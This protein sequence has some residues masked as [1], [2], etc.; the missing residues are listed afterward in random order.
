MVRSALPILESLEI[1]GDQAS[2]PAVKRM[3]WDVGRCV[4]EGMPLSRAFARHPHIFDTTYVSLVAAGEASGNLDLMLERLTNH[5]DFSVKLNAKIQSALVYP[6]IVIMTAL[7]IV[8][9]LAAFVL[10]T[11][12]DIFV[13]LDIA[14]PLAT[15]IL[16]YGG[17][18]L[19]R[20]WHLFAL[21]GAAGL[22]AFRLWF[23]S[24]RHAETVDRLLLGLPLVGGL[25]R[26]IVLTRVLR[27]MGSLLESGITILLSL[28]LAKDAA[29]NRVFQNLFE[30]VGREVREGRILSASLSQS[31]HI[32]RV[33]IGMIA[34]GEKTGTL[35][36]VINRVAGFYEA[37]TDSAIKDLFSALEPL[38]IVG[39]GLMVGG[40]AV[41]V[42][43]PMFD[44]VGGIK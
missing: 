13:Q 34:V 18:V 39:L 29:G 36:E 5:L 31:P 23:K 25:I 10:P 32:P 3:L 44:M 40:I 8:I 21:A 14:L 4:S 6:V 11:F 16:L 35:P 12:A 9:F 30:T 43:L 26:N 15:R 19:R 37:E 2:K 38:F 28:E 33:V 7:A 42:L 22:W 27:T 20:S 17:E 1:L 41:S 24:P